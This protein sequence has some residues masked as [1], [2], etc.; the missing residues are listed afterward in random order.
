M[1]W[2]NSILLNLKSKLVFLIIATGISHEQIIAVTPVLA[3]TAQDQQEDLL[4]KKLASATNETEARKVEFQIWEHWTAEAP[5]D[6]IRDKLTRGMEKRREFDLAWAEDLF[7][8]VVRE[9]PEYPEGWNQRGFAR[10]LR[11]N[12]EGSLNDLERAI[13]LEPRHFGSLSGMYHVL[14][15]LNRHEAALRSLHK[16]VT[17]HPW[18][19]ERNDLPEELRPKSIPIQE[20]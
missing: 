3:E 11:G 16:A 10:F 7:D 1:V 8:E 14:R 12:L 15:L 5:S 17:I 18:L 13:E 20:L 9:A 4:F 2:S 6:E 19:K